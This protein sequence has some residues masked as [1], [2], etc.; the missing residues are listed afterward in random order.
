M[1]VLKSRIEGLRVEDSK[2]ETEV[3]QEE[4]SQ[5]DMQEEL[6]REDIKLTV[7]KKPI[8]DVGLV[9]EEL[10]IE[11][12]KSKPED[13][14]QEDIK[15]LSENLTMEDVRQEDSFIEDPRKL[16]EDKMRAIR[17]EAK[18][19][20]TNILE[21]LAEPE[22]VQE[23]DKYRPEDG[24]EQME[25]VIKKGEEKHLGESVVVDIEKENLQ[26]VNNSTEENNLAEIV[27]T[28]EVV[29][30]SIRTEAEIYW[31]TIVGE[32]EKAEPSEP[33]QESSDSRQ[34][35]KPP[36]EPLMH[37][38]T[39]EP[40][41]PAS[42]RETGVQQSSRRGL[43]R[44][45]SN[46]SAR[47]TFSREVSN[48]SEGGLSGLH[49]EPSFI[50]DT[51]VEAFSCIGASVDDLI[52]EIGDDDNISD[53]SDEKEPMGI[54]IIGKLV[55][56]LEDKE[57]EQSFEEES[58]GPAKISVANISLFSNSPSRMDTVFLTES[59]DELNEE[60]E[61]GISI[62]SSSRVRRIS[63][64]S[65]E[66]ISSTPEAERYFM[67]REQSFIS[68]VAKGELDS[69]AVEVS[70]YYTLE[71]SMSDLD[72]RVKPVDPCP[73]REIEITSFD[74][75]TDLTVKPVE[76]RRLVTVSSYEGI[77]DQVSLEN[78]PGDRQVTV[79]ELVGNIGD[80]FEGTRL[81][82]EQAS[83]FEELYARSA[84]YMSGQIV[85]SAL[86]SLGR[87][88]WSAPAG[89]L[90][91][92]ADEFSIRWDPLQDQIQ[93]HWQELEILLGEGG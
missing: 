51:S 54:S 22:L 90:E 15:L 84:E 76:L 21:K 23:E 68:K 47:T 42:S 93:G 63:S 60:E 56:S 24:M 62:P 75:E 13:S 10:S 65:V 85:S 83:S 64:L 39:S 67:K 14:L 41:E 88:R 92:E 44:E 3:T 31:N 18:L 20:W 87:T 66:N 81:M 82:P 38:E 28:P 26:N 12:V 17:T 46:V 7:Q 35:E 58:A 86:D 73:D 32:L 79:A 69:L 48:L 55:L 4:S 34:P 11:N 61:E 77:Y 1:E 49:R 37:A 43:T 40:A 19:Y 45:L 80:R 6:P 91:P 50:Y 52:G 72:L 89:T 71:K 8:E 74:A 5:E 29:I 27:Q 78:V 59:G 9:E 57:R 53:V 2:S 25:Q 30:N 36:L 33:S 16:A 70:D